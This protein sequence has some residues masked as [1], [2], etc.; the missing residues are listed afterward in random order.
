MAAG[1]TAVLL[2]PKTLRPRSHLILTLRLMC[3]TSRSFSVS[4]DD[5]YR[6]LLWHPKLQPGSTFCSPRHTAAARQHS[7][8]RNLALLSGAC[9]HHP[10]AQPP[11]NH[12]AFH[13]RSN[14]CYIVDFGVNSTSGIVCDRMQ[15]FVL[16]CRPE[17]IGLL[18]LFSA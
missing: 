9:S 15:V 12:V 10:A 3:S 6:R 14:A 8:Q 7:E 11:L 1:G 4:G 2:L 17:T 18:G 16:S 5:F 13:T